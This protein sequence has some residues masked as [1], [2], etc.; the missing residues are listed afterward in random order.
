MVSII[1]QAQKNDY[2]RILAF[3]NKAQLNVENI[4]N[5]LENFLLVV[6]ENNE[7][8]ATIGFDLEN[9]KALIRSLA[10]LPTVTQKE[11]LLLIEQC[12]ILATKM[13]VDEIYLLAKQNTNAQLFYFF[14]F[15]QRPMEESLLPLLVKN[16]YTFEEGAVLFQKNVNNWHKLSTI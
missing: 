15:V 5:C 16:G 6:D 1:R 10:I 7:L 2:E 4:S 11:L 12:I 9:K 3:L 8:K 13:E 14:E